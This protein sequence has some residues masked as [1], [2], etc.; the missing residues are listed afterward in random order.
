MQN[1]T[2]T[3]LLPGLLTDR[4]LPALK[5]L[6]MPHL[7]FLLSRATKQPLAPAFS[8]D[9]E[10][11]M[12]KAMMEYQLCKVAGLDKPYPYAPIAALGEGLAR[13]HEYWLFATP[14]QF[15]AGL[16]EV[17]V[18]GEDLQLSQQEAQ[19]I[20]TELNAFLE[21]D[22]LCLYVTEAAH[23]Y[24]RVSNR[25]PPEFPT[26][27][28]AIAKPLAIKHYQAIED[29]YWL[30]LSVELQLLLTRCAFNQQRLAENRPTISGLWM[31][32][33]GVLPVLSDFNY[34]QIIAN[35]PLAEGL[36]LLAGVPYMPLPENAE[37]FV[38][39]VAVNN[40]LMAIDTLQ[41]P[42]FREDKANWCEQ[43]ALLDTQWFLPLLR[44]LEQGALHTLVL[45]LDQHYRFVVT[46]GYLQRWWR[47]GKSID[48]FLVG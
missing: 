23:W 2:L 18:T 42:W 27:W 38:D 10:Q 6:A 20:A 43:A 36:A 31:W 45:Q 47:R 32:G 19:D 7:S 1:N 34:Q 46:R 41:L 4:F 17:M 35:H 15:N 26:W 40:H 25:T 12:Q 28:S 21:A 30:R 24:L 29:R 8:L 14:V 37:Q 22:G 13:A 44:A 48:K 9:E 5:T 3:L 16:H 11:T 39:N 33:G